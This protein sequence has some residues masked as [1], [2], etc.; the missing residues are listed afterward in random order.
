MIYLITGKCVKL[1]ELSMEPKDKTTDDTIK[2][3]YETPELII[4]GDVDELTHF[5]QGG[6]TD[7]DGGTSPNLF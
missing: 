5:L 1:K 3:T 2:E 6:P 4:H 7:G